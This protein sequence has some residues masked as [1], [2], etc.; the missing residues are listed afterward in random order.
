MSS[1]VPIVVLDGEQRAALAVVRSL[2][3]AGHRVHVASSDMKSLAGG[4]RYCASETAVPDPAV[5]TAE[6][7]RAIAGL[8]RR[9]EAKVL[10]PITDASTLAVLERSDQFV[11]AVIPSADLKHFRQASD[12]EATLQIA[13]RIGI[14]VPPQ[15]IV[16]EKAAPLPEVSDAQFPVVLKP[17]RSVADSAGTRVKVGVSYATSREELRRAI[18]SLAGYAF[19]LLIQARIQ[20]PGVGVFSLRWN[21]TIYA[22]FAHRRLREFPPSG[23]VSVLCESIEP[24]Q[25]LVAQA[26]ALLAA[27]DW[28]G[29]AMV[30]FKHDQRSDTHYLM[31]VN[32]RFWGS[33]QLAIDAGVD[34]PLYLVQL[35]L[36]E[37]VPT[38]RTWR[39]GVRSRWGWGEVDHLIA[40]LRR[41]RRALDLP[42][43]APGRLRALFEALTSWRP[44]QRGAVFR[45]ADPNPALRE[46][47]AWVKALMG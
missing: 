34:F 33:L 43:D 20:G 44:G 12:K 40:R 18:E 10:L 27:L 36:G 35:A 24:P 30:E 2:G 42:P 8:V 39:V 4:S 32:P 6:F 17:P 26:E 38:V 41:S 45:L 37:P 47:L 9:S 28:T 23:G 5:Q 15:W 21:G 29:V 25:A 14:A 3:R 7:A 31:E 46:S 11:G 16:M 1:G 19:P 13:Q 22:T